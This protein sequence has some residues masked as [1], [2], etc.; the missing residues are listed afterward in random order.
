[1]KTHSKL[2]NEWKSL[3]T[4]LSLSLR[5]EDHNNSLN[6][7]YCIIHSTVRVPLTRSALSTVYIGTPKDDGFRD[8][9]RTYGTNVDKRWMLSRFWYWDVRVGY[10]R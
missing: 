3:E 6:P 8:G 7:S 5:M 1:M 10:P 9:L 4:V 2:D